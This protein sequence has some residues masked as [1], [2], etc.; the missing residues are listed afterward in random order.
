MALISM[1][2]ATMITMPK[3]MSLLLSTSPSS[4]ME[5]TLAEDISLQ[6]GE[7]QENKLMKQHCHLCS[8]F[9]LESYPWKASASST[10]SP[11]TS[12]AAEGIKEAVVMDQCNS[13]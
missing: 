8:V 1:L 2:I 10:M 3:V 6:L 13:E 4:S 5:P 12:M 11:M 7:S 9:E